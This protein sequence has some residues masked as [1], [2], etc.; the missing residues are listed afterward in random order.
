MP[1][2]PE[3]KLQPEDFVN[4]LREMNTFI[5]VMVD[6]LVELNARAEKYARLRA[7]EG[8]SIADVMTHPVITVRPDSSLAEVA[9]L[10]V[11]QRISGAPVVD[12]EK[13]LIGIVTDADFLRVLGVPGHHPTHNLWHTLE[14]LFVHDLEFPEP[15][16]RIAD[17]MV[18]NVV[19]VSREQ[20][21]HDAIDAMKKHRI[22]RIIVCD[23]KRRVTGIL[24]HTD[25]MR[26]FFDRIRGNTFKQSGK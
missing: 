19:T 4:A 11:T 13:R 20:S 5:D 7:A 17:L 14:A 2:H 3:H 18:T 25:L 9:H 24:T 22:N 1:K 23:D 12:G 15:E 10:F 6:D 21:I 16:N 8:H 26:I